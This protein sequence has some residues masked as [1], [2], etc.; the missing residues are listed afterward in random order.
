[1]HFASDNSLFLSIVFYLYYFV[2]YFV[3][4]GG[5]DLL[6]P[7][8]VKVHIGIPLPLPHLLPTVV[9]LVVG[10]RILLILLIQNQYNHDTFCNSFLSI[11]VFVVFVVFVVSLL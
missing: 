10:E 4:I 7:V 3:I 5:E 8:P 11:F 2:Y 9:D 1:M 6:L